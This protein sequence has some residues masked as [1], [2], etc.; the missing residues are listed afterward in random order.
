MCVCVC[1]VG[2]GGY[3][4]VGNECRGLGLGL[5]QCNILMN[6]KGWS[7]D[8][9]GMLLVYCVIWWPGSLD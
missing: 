5:V 9:V 4:G 3:C 7:I 1:L 8:S 6:S 2:G